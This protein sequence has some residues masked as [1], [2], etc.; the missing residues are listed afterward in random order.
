MCRHVLILAYLAVV[1]RYSNSSLPRR[2]PA[3]SD[4][5]EEEAT[6]DATKI[7][8]IQAEAVKEKGPVAHFSVCLSCIPFNSAT[9]KCVDNT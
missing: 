5:I 7:L 3:L 9:S 6:T 4:L 2:S 8:T 1:T